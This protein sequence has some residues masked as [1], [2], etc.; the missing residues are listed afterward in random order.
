MAISTGFERQWYLEGFG[1]QNRGC[2]L[3][4]DSMQAS[5][6]VSMYYRLFSYLFT[7]FL[8]K[9]MTD[10]GAKATIRGHDKA[11]ALADPFLL[12]RRGFKTNKSI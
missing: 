5:I 6:V 7:S 3:W 4:E 2:V 8:R 12:I 10:Q 11:H 9:N 1:G